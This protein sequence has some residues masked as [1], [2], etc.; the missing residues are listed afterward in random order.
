VPRNTLTTD[1]IEDEVKKAL[2]GSQVEVELGEDDFDKCLKDCVRLYN[3]T[4]PGHGR[5]AIPVT[6]QQKKYGPLN[7]W[8]P[9]APTTA[10]TIPPTIQG[11]VRGQF[12][13]NQ[14]PVTDPFD[15]I[16]N[17]IGR[18]LSGQGTPFGE[19]DQQLQYIKTAR[20]VAS[21]DPDWQQAWEGDQFWIYVDIARTP[22][23]FAAE[24]TFH[25]TPDD[26]KLSGVSMIPDGDTDFLVGFVL[27]RAKQILANVRGKFQG[28]VNEEGATD[29]IDFEELRQEGKDEEAEWTEELKKRRRPLIP[30][31]G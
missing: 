19:I 2:G 6:P 25:F 5:I 13:T 4:R 17:G 7:S 21:S 8:P 27:A 22:V 30:V 9:G 20:V 29:P 12:V 23:L 26:D 18:V 14:A 16:N 1:V 31:I 15:T 3:R 24:Y 10:L 11:I 28:V